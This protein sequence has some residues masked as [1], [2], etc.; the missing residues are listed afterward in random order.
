MAAALS[1]T[2][3]SK[4]LGYVIFT[5]VALACIGFGIGVYARQAAGYYRAHV[6]QRWPQV[7]ATIVE[8]QLFDARDTAK[9]RYLR[10]RY[11]KARCEYSFQGVRY[12]SDCIQTAPTNSLSALN[13]YTSA[14]RVGSMHEGRINPARPAEIFINQPDAQPLL[15][16]GILLVLPLLFLYIGCGLLYAMYFKK[17]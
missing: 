6:A 9:G 15:M 2:R 4:A 1:S 10:S 14:Y 13:A 11:L 7:Q 8:A 5:L 17:R 12:V 3:F 16:R